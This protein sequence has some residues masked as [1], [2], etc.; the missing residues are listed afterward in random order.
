M[1]TKPTR[2]V[3]MGHPQLTSHGYNLQHHDRNIMHV[4]GSK[5]KQD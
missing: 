1:L 2:H 5:T 3:A 4:M